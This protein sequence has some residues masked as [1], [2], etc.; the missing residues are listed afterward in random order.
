MTISANG[1]TQFTPDEITFT[2]IE[3]W[4]REY[5]YYLRLS[6]ASINY[7]LNSNKK[8]LICLILDKIKLRMYYC[9]KF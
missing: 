2:P 3:S 8:K 5:S 9:P 1:V 4:K 7:Y 6:K